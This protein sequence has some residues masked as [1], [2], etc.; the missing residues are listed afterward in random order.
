MKTEYHI[1]FNGG[2]LE[3]AEY[4]TLIK[5]LS[6]ENGVWTFLN[7]KIGIILVYKLIPN[8]VPGDAYWEAHEIVFWNSKV[9]KKSTY[10]D[11]NATWASKKVIEEL[12]KKI[13]FDVQLKQMLN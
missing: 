6:I 8:S 7:R 5:F 3:D 13:E 9:S 2:Y 11:Y 4:Q 12:I 10:R 1:N